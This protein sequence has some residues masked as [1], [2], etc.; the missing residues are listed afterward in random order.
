MP[1]ERLAFAIAVLTRSTFPVSAT[2]PPM[3][4]G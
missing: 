4:F 2:T 3:G 1:V